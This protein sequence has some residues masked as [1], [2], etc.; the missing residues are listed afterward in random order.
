M[1]NV[2][3]SMNFKFIL[4]YREEMMETVVVEECHDQ[5]CIFEKESLVEIF[6]MIK[7]RHWRERKLVGGHYL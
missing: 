6:K 4:C 2:K 1:K 3:Q 5:I 7:A